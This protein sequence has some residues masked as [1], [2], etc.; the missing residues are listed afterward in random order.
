V[1]PRSGRFAGT[2]ARHA[3]WCSWCGRE[4]HL[5]PNID[6][7]P[8]AKYVRSRQATGSSP[9]SAT[10]RFAEVLMRPSLIAA[11]A[12]AIVLSTRSAAA[13][14]GYTWGRDTLRF[15]E[16]THTDVRLTAPQGE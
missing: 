11:G 3:Q 16:V 9:L 1:F 15:R 4:S 10:P 5:T 8:V 14:S 6:L 7:Q 12:L 13:Q 2:V